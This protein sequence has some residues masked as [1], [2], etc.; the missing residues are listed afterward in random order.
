MIPFSR[1]PL[2]TGILRSTN[3]YTYGHC[4]RQLYYSAQTNTV[5]VTEKD[6]ANFDAGIAKHKEIQ[7]VKYPYFEHEKTLVRTIP[8]ING[9]SRVGATFDC[10]SPEK[11]V[12]IK[13]K[14]SYG[15]N[16]YPAYIQTLIQR[17]VVRTVPIY[18]YSY[19]DDQ[20]FL[21]KTDPEMSTVYVGRI[22]TALVNKP[23]KIPNANP[24]KFPCSTCGFQKKCYSEEETTWENFKELSTP[25]IEKLKAN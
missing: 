2:K 9:V 18:C 5:Q 1:N 12:E 22:L 20:E 16:S 8:E 17:F 25:I 11:A 7:N 10:F 21:L 23:P 6:Q 4:A 19:R 24:N 3:G 15:N 14:Y 13:P